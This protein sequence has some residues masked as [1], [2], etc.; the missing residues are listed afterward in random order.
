MVMKK[1]SFRSM[2]K[3]LSQPCHKDLSYLVNV[4]IALTSELLIVFTG[5]TL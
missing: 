1:T 2:A 3:L 5:Q 4:N